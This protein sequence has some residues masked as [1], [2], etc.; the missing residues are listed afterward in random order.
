M[1][2]LRPMEMAAVKSK[3]K[4]EAEFKNQKKKNK[5]YL[6]ISSDK[7]HTRERRAEF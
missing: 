4:I 7:I 1:E 3:N 6:F 5:G 2:E